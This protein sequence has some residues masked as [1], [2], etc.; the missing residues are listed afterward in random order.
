MSDRVSIKGL[1]KASVLA[2]LYNAS[3]PLNMGYLQYDPTPMTDAE[4][5]T[6]IAK[7][8]HFDYLK[9]RVMK[10]DLSEDSVDPWLYDRD[11]GEGAFLK[12]VNGLRQETQTA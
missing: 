3:H 2:A 11:N 4:A 6:L 9:G 12:V 7:Q 5:A 8:T 10:V 1:S